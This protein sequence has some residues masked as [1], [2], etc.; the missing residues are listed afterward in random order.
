MSRQAISDGGENREFVIHDQ[1]R[2]LSGIHRLG[3]DGANRNISMVDLST[4]S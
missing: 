4:T 3:V 2:S 1:N